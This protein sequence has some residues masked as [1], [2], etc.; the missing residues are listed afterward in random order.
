MAL[1]VPVATEANDDDADADEPEQLPRLESVDEPPITVAVS[2]LPADDW[3]LQLVEPGQLT[4]NGGDGGGDRQI[5]SI[6]FTFSKSSRDKILFVD[7]GLQG[8]GL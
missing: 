8:E 4:C 5:V 2:G 6:S 1:K 3:A 7:I